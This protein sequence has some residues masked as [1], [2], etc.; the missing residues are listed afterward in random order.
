[1]KKPVKIVII[2]A[3]SFDTASVRT[4]TEEGESDTRIDVLYQMAMYAGSR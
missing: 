3:V 1:M 2:A 4:G